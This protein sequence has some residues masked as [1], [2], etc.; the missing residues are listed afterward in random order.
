MRLEL[1]MKPKNKLTLP[2]AYNHYLQ[3][4]FYH[5][6]SD[7]KLARRVHDLGYGD[8]R[9]FKLFTFSSLR[10]KH[11]INIK[12]KEITFDEYVYFSISS[13]DHELFTNLYHYLIQNNVVK[14][15]YQELEIERIKI[16]EFKSRASE[17]NINMLSPIVLYS[18]I[19][20]NNRKKTIYYN[21]INNEFNELLNLNIKNKLKAINKEYLY[22][23]IKIKPIDFS[24]KN[25]VITKYKGFIIKG[26]T[27]KY[28]IEGKNEIL[29]FLY[30][31][32]LGGKNSQG[33][34]MFEII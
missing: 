9:K 33:F 15:K 18:T 28:L 24:T 20:E 19:E 29:H 30:D 25:Q 4:L 16:E 1:K 23:P 7:E 11:K 12:S 13:Y 26:Y 2:L 21:P 5:M 22:S 34:G 14:L 6:I 10:G 32:G 27:G 3:G 17:L 8:L 31:V